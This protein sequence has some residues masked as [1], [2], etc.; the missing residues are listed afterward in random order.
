MPIP[1]GGSEDPP[2]H[3]IEADLKTRFYTAVEADLKTRFYTA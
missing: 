3:R 1:I 2:L